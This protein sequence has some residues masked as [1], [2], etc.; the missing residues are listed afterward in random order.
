MRH[1][2]AVALAFLLVLVACGD[3]TGGSTSAVS[4]TV[5]TTTTAPTTT[6]T[7]PGFE[8]TSEDGDL[9]VEVPFEAM[10]SDPG[11]TIRLLAGDEYPPELASAAENPKS[12]I[13]NLEPDGTVF[14]A[15]VTV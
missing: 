5:A 11:I 15:P 14:A 13:Y 12:R 1:R 3:D 9:T 2:Y 4:T 8:V 10:A 6:T 7:P